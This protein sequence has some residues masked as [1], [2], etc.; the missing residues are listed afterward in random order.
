MFARISFLPI[1]QNRNDFEW[2]YNCYFLK[3]SMVIVISLKTEIF[4]KPQPQS[5]RTIK[6][7]PNK[8]NVLNDLNGTS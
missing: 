2:F 7:T 3:N 1:Y 8:L 6:M 5:K 4:S